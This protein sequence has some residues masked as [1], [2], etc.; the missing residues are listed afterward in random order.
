[1][2]DIKLLRKEMKILVHNLSK[3]YREIKLK[4]KKNRI[5]ER[6]KVKLLT[7][8]KQKVYLCGGNNDCNDHS[9][10]E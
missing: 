1:M 6:L 9:S 10:G 4:E 5:A 2:Q 8:K 7:D 3:F